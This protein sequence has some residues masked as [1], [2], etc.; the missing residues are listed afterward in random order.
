[1]P[2]PN[3][4]TVGTDTDGD[5]TRVREAAGAPSNL[6]ARRV[7]E[8]STVPD[9]ASERR[10]VRYTLIGA[11]V[12]L[13]AGTGLFV[14]RP[15]TTPPIAVSVENA[16]PEAVERVL[17]INGRV[18][19]MQ[20]VEVRPL[21]SGRITV[22]P[23]S[24]GDLVAAGA[25]LAVLDARAQAAAVR[26]AMAGLDAALVAQGAAKEGRTRA[27]ALGGATSRVA[28]EE[29][30][31][32]ELTAG[33]EVQRMTAL[34]EQAQLALSLYSVKAPL[35]G[36]VADLPVVTGQTV[37]PGTV[38]MTV[39]DMGHLVVEADVD[40]THAL[41]LRTGLAA[42]MRA[43][44]SSDVLTG[45]VSRVAQEVDATTGAIAVTLTPDA[46]LAAP[47]GLTVTAN[48]VIEDRAAAITVPRAAVVTDEA[49]TA[50]FVLQGATA[51]RRAV[52]VIEWPAARLIV[53]DGLS[54]GDPVIAD[55][56]GL[57]DGAVVAVGVP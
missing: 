35:A 2:S 57:K 50:V 5:E 16:V 34:L 11:A 25:V 31:R 36:T 54:P 38:L 9:M 29:A 3:D 26:Q 7:P 55:A 28:K 47:I 53:T 24:E 1:M 19:A 23:V 17:A 46:R 4:G 15:W 8:P 30:L 41:E 27:E 51:A 42:T 49:G 18:A 45:R 13:L 56:T 20:T 22:L 33:Q 40:E 43:T 14:W 32:A 12:L 6:P 37:D 44:G 21:V 39:A 48:I 52:A 10:F